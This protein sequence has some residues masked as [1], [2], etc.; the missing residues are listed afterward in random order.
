MDLNLDLENVANVA[1]VANVDDYY[2]FWQSR[3]LLYV[4]VINGAMC[5]Q[6]FQL[7]NSSD[8]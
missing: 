6:K 4:S 3:L 5:F 1:N 7:F 2:N 8:L